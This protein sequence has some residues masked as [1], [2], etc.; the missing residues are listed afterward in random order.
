MNELKLEFDGASHKIAEKCMPMYG[1]A[2]VSRLYCRTRLG[3]LRY[4]L[5]TVLGEEPELPED[6]FG[7]GVVVTDEGERRSV[8]TTTWDGQR[9]ELRF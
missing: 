5:R 8:A 6:L 1:S 9:L 2:L 3:F 7:T 4:A